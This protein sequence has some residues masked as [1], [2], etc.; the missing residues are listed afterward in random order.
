MHA[1]RRA[2]L[3]CL[4]I[5][6]TVAFGYA[7]AGIPNVEL[8]TMTVFLSGYLLG[9][10]LGILVGIV[11][12]GIHALFNPLG[13]SLP[14]LL[15]SQA[16]GFAVIAAAGATLGP[17]IQRF[18]YRV[19]A[20]ILSGAIGFVLTLQYDI[21]TNIAAY[22]IVMGE[23]VSES[24]WGFVLAGVLFMGMHIIWNTGLF[25]L[26]VKPILVVLSKYRYEL[27]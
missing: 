20:V 1:T 24:L 23:G 22:Y 11:S 21:L 6:L 14:P 2:L 5:S 10:R 25:L 18:R 8:M 17:V 15:L 4:L 19:A 13:A 26:I 12:I 3:A 16:V 7:L 27:S 9:V